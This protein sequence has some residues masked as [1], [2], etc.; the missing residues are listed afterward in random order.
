M[1]AMAPGSDDV[2]GAARLIDAA[3]RA[4]DAYR[5]MVARL[6]C[7][8]R[9]P[10]EQLDVTLYA[11]GRSDGDLVADVLVAAAGEVQPGDPCERCRKGRLRV[12]TSR[13]RGS[14]VV[15]FLACSHCGHAPPANKRTLPAALVPRR[16]PRRPAKRKS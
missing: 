14:H 6:R 5:A 9:V 10:R 4:E 3:R 13:R 7:G 1:T 16:R 2:T 8:R 11:A 15:Q 12:S